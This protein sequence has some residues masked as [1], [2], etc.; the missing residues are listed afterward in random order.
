MRVSGVP[1]STAIRPS[2][3]GSYPVLLRAIVL[4]CKLEGEHGLSQKL[5]NLTFATGNES[6][7][8]EVEAGFRHRER[9]LIL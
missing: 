2:Q 1:D 7:I 3:S 5:E 9:K 6:Q 4:E 8:F